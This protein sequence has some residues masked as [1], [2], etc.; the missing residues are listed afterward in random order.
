MT[1]DSARHD[2]AISFVFRIH[3]ILSHQS[4]R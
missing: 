2:G 1:A 3:S 4:S